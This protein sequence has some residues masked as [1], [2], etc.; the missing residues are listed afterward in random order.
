MKSRAD[1]S[2]LSLPPVPLERV[3]NTSG[4]PLHEVETE[5]PIDLAKADI[6][7]AV[8]LTLQRTGSGLKDFGDKSQVGRWCKGQ[9]NPNIARLWQ[10]PNVRREFLVA[11]LEVSGLARVR[12]S[13]TFDERRRSA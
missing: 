7:R 11:L 3:E 1:H 2:Q 4:A 10:R 12:L 5:L 8:E 6:G 9:E 13:V